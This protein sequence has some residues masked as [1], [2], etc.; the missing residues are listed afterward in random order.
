MDL[1]NSIIAGTIGQVIGGLVLIWLQQRRSKDNSKSETTFLLPI[2]WDR[3]FHLSVLAGFVLI[4]AISI[5]FLLV[6]GQQS[7][8]SKEPSK[9]IEWGMLPLALYVGAAIIL[10]AYQIQ[11]ARLQQSILKRAAK[12]PGRW[13][14]YVKDNCMTDNGQEL[15]QKHALISGILVGIVVV[16]PV[17]LLETLMSMPGDSSVLSSFLVGS[18]GLIALTYLC[19]QDDAILDFVVLNDNRL[20]GL[21]VAGSLLLVFP[22]FL[23]PMRLL[24]GLGTT[25]VFSALATA[26]TAITWSALFAGAFVLGDW[27]SRVL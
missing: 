10:R 25:I 3:V 4:G 14:E 7:G 2:H 24:G 21:V 5:T 16:L 19:I 23:L 26:L 22:T 12:N 11:Q 15:A 18:L 27:F 6:D 17:L 20:V 9:F 8:S 13:I 1:F